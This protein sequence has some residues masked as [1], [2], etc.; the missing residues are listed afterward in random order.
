MRQ[1]RAR[2]RSRPR[3]STLP[4]DQITR[5]QNAKATLTA[6][7]AGDAEAA[8]VYVTDVKSAGS[9]VKGVKIPDDENQIAVYPI[10]PLADAANPKTAKAFVE[11]R[12]VA[13]GSEDPQDLRVPRTLIDR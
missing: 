13:C 2:L 3:A 12:R 6:V 1:V 7:S 9:S 8:I 5:G 4:V 11:V 10:A